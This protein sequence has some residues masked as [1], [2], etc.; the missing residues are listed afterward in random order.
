MGREEGGGSSPPSEEDRLA[1]LRRY[2]V[3]D[4]PSEQVFDDLAGL[5]VRLCGTPIAL[6]SFVDEQRQWSKSRVGFEAV[7]TPRQFSFCDRAI[8]QSDIFVVNDASRDERFAASPLVT[9]PPGIRFYAAAPLVAPAG[10]ALGTLCIMDRVPRELTPSQAHSLRVLARQVVTQLELRRRSLELAERERLL[11]TIFDSE[12]ECVKLLDSDGSVRMMNRAGLKMIE[13]DSL[14]QIAGQRLYPLIAPEQRAAFVAL[15]DRI[16]H[17]ETGSLE[18]RITGLKGAT[19]WLE[20]RAAPLRDEAGEVRALL[21]ITREITERKKADAALRESENNFR[22]LFEQATEG[23]FVTD[24]EGRFVDVNPAACTLTGYTR[25]EIAAMTVADLV[26]PEEVPRVASAIAELSAGQVITGEWRARRKDGCIYI[27][28]VSAKRLADGRLRAF[29]RDITERTQLQAQL[30]QAQKMESLGRLAGG[31]AHDFNNLLTV[32]NG[33]ADFAIADL[34]DAA[35]L[36]DDL[37]QIRLAGERAASLTRQLLAMSR[38][39]ILKP[40]VLDLTAVVRR[41]EGMLRRLIPE[42][43]DLAFSLSDPLGSVNADP[44]QIEQVVLNLAVNA[45]DAMPDGGTLT[46]ETRDVDLGVGSAAHPNLAP[47]RYVLLSVRD[48]G[49]GM[50]EGTRKQ[51]FEPFFTTKEPGKGTGLG[52]PTVYGIV[53]QSGGG[54]WVSSEPGKG[55]TFTIHLPRVDGVPREA[56]SA[57]P[58]VPVPGTETILLVEDEPALRALT[59]RILHSAGYQVLEAANGL[60]AL[61]LAEQ[62][63]GTVHLMITDVVMPGM[64]GRELAERLSRFAPRMRV[65]FTSGYTDDSILRLGVLDDASRFLNKPYTPSGLRRRVRDLLDAPKP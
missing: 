51:I 57:H 46:I 7:E 21:G 30:L 32:I 17:G 41:M 20:T 4:T 60:D 29:A 48:T 26:L 45:Q 56:P 25:E 16:F 42:H 2:A 33:T 59:K 18:F 24:P 14:E 23:I 6:I 61:R 3:L 35:A 19:R 8:R 49:M 12:P 39:Q 28:E 36:R 10:E 43:I 63:R 58:A 5:A 34:P 52:L 53:K 40:E 31:I 62:H 64:N 22:M 50:D 37:E 15:T 65:L 54:I 27:V 44:S 13:A 11:R 9:G 38:Q 55:S 1:A 47:G